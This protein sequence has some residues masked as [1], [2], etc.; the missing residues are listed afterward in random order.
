MNLRKIF[1]IIAKDIRMQLADPTALIIY[2]TAPI[3]LTLVISLAFSGFAGGGI[4]IEG[5]P[6]IIVN[7]D[8]GSILVG[9]NMGERL[10][11][12]F[13]NL[14]GALENT[15]DIETMSDPEAARAK[16]RRGEAKVAVI[17][18]PNFSE[19]FTQIGTQKVEAEVY[20]DA[21]AAL[22]PQ[23]VL[24]ITEGFIS[25]VASSSIAT[26]AAALTNPIQ[27]AQISQQIAEQL[28]SNPPI[29]YVTSEGNANQNQSFNPIQV[30]APSMAVFF[31]LFSMSFGVVGILDEREK[32]TLQ[33][34]FVTP[35]SRTSILI[36][37]MGGTYL[38]GVIQLV[39]LIITTSIMGQVIF[40]G[41]VPIWGGSILLMIVTIVVTVAAAIGLGT[42]ICGL[43]KD[44]QQAIVLSSTIPI[45]MGIFGGSFF[46]S[47]S[48]APPAGV[49]SYATLNYWGQSAFIELSRG[50]IPT[51]NIIA[52]II[53][54]LVTFTLGLILFSRKLD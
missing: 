21:N 50:N 24:S 7:Q 45:V 20:G 27:I 14:P 35:T 40:G 34:M 12:V 48:T 47:G 38:N 52:L 3:L 8:R 1:L 6:I 44:R 9:G 46:A 18:P 17:I 49:L 30:I 13:S 43:A 26:S 28:Q 10:I 25:S 41:S 19:S 31:L 37:K 33:R 32:W 11:S 39:V 51:T 29:S 22:E 4:P 5:A 16:V 53:F 23:I 2:Y 54:F 15:F 36:G 42:I